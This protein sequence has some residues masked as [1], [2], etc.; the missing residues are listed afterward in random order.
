MVDG[1]SP[2]RNAPSARPRMPGRGRTSRGSAWRS[3]SSSRGCN[4]RSPAAP[5]VAS[6]SRQRTKSLTASTISC[7]VE[8]PT[9][10]D[11]R[12][13]GRSL[14]LLRGPTEGTPSRPGRRGPVGEPSDGPWV[15]RRRMALLGGRRVSARRGEETV[16]GG[17]EATQSGGNRGVGHRECGG[18]TPGA[19]EPDRILVS[20]ATARPVGTYAPLSSAE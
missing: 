12:C 4:S 10:P 20:D 17:L 2:G 19:A 13:A 8:A 11:R 3:P 5:T 9:E 1:P 6:A 18:A 15:V 14:R 16:A 7:V